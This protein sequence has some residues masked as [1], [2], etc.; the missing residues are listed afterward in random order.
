MDPQRRRGAPRRARQHQG[1]SEEVLWRALIVQ[2]V[3]SQLVNLRGPTRRSPCASPTGELQIHGGSTT[4]PPARCRCGTSPAWRGSGPR[5]WRTASTDRAAPLDRS[6]PR[7]RAPG[8]GGRRGRRAARRSAPAVGCRRPRPR[9]RARRSGGAHG[10]HAAHGPGPTTTVPAP[11]TS[12]AGVT[13]AA[14]ASVQAGPVGPIV[15]RDARSRQLQ[16]ALDGWARST[17]VTSV[18]VAL[19]VNGPDVAGIGA[20]RRPARARSR[21]A[22]PRDEHHQDGHR[23]TRAA[24]GRGRSAVAR[25]AGAAHRRAGP[26]RA[27]GHHRPDAARPSRGLAEYTEAPG[28]RADR[29]V[30]RRRPWR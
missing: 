27:R 30:G 19:R 17:G 16:S 28:Y 23:G 1:A 29:L 14:P 6:P 7:S 26:G 5:T 24:I 18:I 11:A 8:L 9:R 20:R 12:P 25:R 22:L 4:S 2:N 21:H 15:P 3:I 10:H 13:T